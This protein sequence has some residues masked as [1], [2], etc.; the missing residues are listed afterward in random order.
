MYSSSS[1]KPGS[2][3][4]VVIVRLYNRR[5]RRLG[6]ADR[7]EEVE[8]VPDVTGLFAGLLGLPLEAHRPRRRASLSEAVGQPRAE[9]DAFLERAQGCPQAGLQRRALLG[10][11]ALL[12]V[13]VSDPAAVAQDAVLVALP[14][15]AAAFGT[16]EA[17]DASG[18]GVFRGFGVRCLFDHRLL[19][20]AFGVVGDTCSGPRQ[21]RA[22]AADRRE[23]HER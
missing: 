16:R 20:T 7:G 3:A 1:S 10:E 23:R 8:R 17:G 21:P 13:G 15:G 22:P 14:E 11:H 18:L 5:S 2:E 9:G 6:L 12:G 19:H 4:V